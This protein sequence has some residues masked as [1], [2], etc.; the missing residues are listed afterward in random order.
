M[1]WY[2]C[3]I[4]NGLVDTSLPPLGIYDNIADGMKDAMKY[5]EKHI[6]LLI[7]EKDLLRLDSKIN[8]SGNSNSLS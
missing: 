1:K 2:L 7:S 4:T 3:L 8:S 6:C 5:G